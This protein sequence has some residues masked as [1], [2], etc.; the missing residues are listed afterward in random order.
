L[1]LLEHD[2]GHPDGVGVFAAPPGQVG[3]VGVPPAEQGVLNLLG[4]FH[5]FARLK[6]KD[7]AD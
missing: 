5:Q 4:V 1:R 2:F 3:V 6:I 7:C